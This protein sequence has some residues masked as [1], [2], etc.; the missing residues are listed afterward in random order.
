VHEH[1][2]ASQ[3]R[4]P[5]KNYLTPLESPG[6]VTGCEKRSNCLLFCSPHLL[7]I[8]RS[9]LKK[10]L[11]L[12]YMCFV[13][14]KQTNWEAPFAGYISRYC[15]S[16][17]QQIKTSGVPFLKAPETYRARTEPFLV[18]LYP[19]TENLHTPETSCMKG[20]SIH[21]KNTWIKQL[22]NHKL[23]DFAMA[24]RVRKLFGTFEKRTPGNETEWLLIKTGFRA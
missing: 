22:C 9:H 10:S 11:F 4:Y 5:R 12:K 15:S 2:F 13:K 6:R 3:A 18:H 20:T 17:G 8:S 16:F 19:K 24:F 14:I 7:S 23:R 1:W 21:I